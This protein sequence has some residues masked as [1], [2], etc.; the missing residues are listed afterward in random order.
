MDC[1][2]G[3]AGPGQGA[4]AGEDAAHLSGDRAEDEGLDGELLPPARAVRRH[5]SGAEAA[6][7]GERIRGEH[8]AGERSLKDAVK[9]FR[10]CGEMLLKAKAELGH[11]HFQC[12]LK[13]NVKIHPRSAQRYILLA[14]S[15]AN[16]S[17]A[18]ATRVSHLSL[19]DAIGE[20]SRLSNTATKLGGPALG[21]ALAEARTN[22][23]K[24]TIT[25]QKNLLCRGVP[26]AGPTE[27]TSTALLPSIEGGEEDDEDIGPASP[28]QVA[29]MQARVDAILGQRRVERST[30]QMAGDIIDFLCRVPVNKFAPAEATE[31]SDPAMVAAIDR[32]V[33]VALPWVAN[34]SDAWR[35]RGGARPE[36]LSPA[37][38]DL[39]SGILNSIWIAKGRQSELTVAD[40][41]AALNTVFQQI[42]RGLFSSWGETP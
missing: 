38:D 11:G 17:A 2:E 42:A 31:I 15:M 22:P 41:R 5:L 36:P 18:D 1:E 35:E 34:F 28:E 8:E 19:R 7:L 4:A 13:S 27:W 9:H 24:A 10:R 6:D 14:S 16:L 39:L 26:E 21:K 23:L 33:D 32:Y 30:I 3:A 29:A 25:H 37:G 40:L 12:F 20:L